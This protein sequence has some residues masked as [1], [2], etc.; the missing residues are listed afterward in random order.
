MGDCWP[1]ASVWIDFL[2]EEAQDFWGNLY[3]YDQFIGSTSRYHAWND[4]NEPSVFSTPE[5]TLPG[6]S[7]HYKAD[8]RVIFHRDFHN[9][10]GAL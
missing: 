4:M 10:Y 8:G 2:N 1:G 9:A 7:R 6:L 5:K 3:S